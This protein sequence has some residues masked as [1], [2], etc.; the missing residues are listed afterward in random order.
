VN[1]Y[2]PLSDKQKPSDQ[3]LLEA[4][5]DN[6]DR[7]EKVAK[8]YQKDVLLTEVGFRSVEKPWEHP[9]AEANGQ[10]Y[11]EEAQARCYEALFK[12]GQEREWLKG[13]YWWKW[14]SYIPYA[15]EARTSFTACGKEAQEILARWY[16]ET[17]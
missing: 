17:Y 7:I 9:H 15:K 13:Y 4:A 6:F 14:P 8:H 16:R 1:C 3:E 11:N 10:A 5:R 2:Y 12:A